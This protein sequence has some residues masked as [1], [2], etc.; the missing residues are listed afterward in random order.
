MPALFRVFVNPLSFTAF[1]IVSKENST[2]LL[3]SFFEYVIVLLLITVHVQE[4]FMK[5]SAVSRAT[6]VEV[7]FFPE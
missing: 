1:L 3:K 2:D 4:R 7:Q 5:K 6:I